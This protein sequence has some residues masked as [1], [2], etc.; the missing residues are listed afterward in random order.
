MQPTPFTTWLDFRA[1]TRPG[2][3]KAGFPIWVESLQRI[4]SVAGKTIYRIRFRHLG[5]LGDELQFRIF[6]RDDVNAGPSIT[7]W[8]ETG[9]QPF[10]A[11]PLG[12]G[13]GVDTSETLLVPAGAL[14]YL[15]VEVPGDG[16]NV[17]GAFVTSLRREAIWHSLDFGASDPLIDPFGVP[18][19]TDVSEDDRLLYGRVRATL[20]AE[21]LTLDPARSTDATYEFSLD[22]APLLAAVKF[23]ILGADPTALPQAFINGQP[24]G[25]ASITFPDLADPAF[26]GESRPLEKNLRFR[27]TGWLRG[28]VIVPGPMLLGGL[29]SFVLRVNEDTSPVIVRAVEIELKHPSAVFDYDF[30]P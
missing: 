4:T 19:P 25:T 8:T 11:G 10:S 29:N 6:F 13:F 14:D 7:G 30:K 16:K 2:A 27:Y 5:G 3:P 21:P 9:S 28:Q 24:L 18:N 26:H 12:Q 22:K 17:R 15:D 1:L 23:E 20:D